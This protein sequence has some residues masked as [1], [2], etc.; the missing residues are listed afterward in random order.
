MDNRR[1]EKL[2]R[3]FSSGEPKKPYISHKNENRA[4]P[5]YILFNKQEDFLKLCTK[6]YVLYHNMLLINTDHIIF[7]AVTSLFGTGS[8][9]PM[10]GKN[11]RHLGN[12]GRLHTFQ[13]KNKTDISFRF[14]AIIN[15]QCSLSLR[16]LLWE[17]GLRLQFAIFQYKIGKV[18]LQVS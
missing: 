7:R 4:I 10:I 13:M 9:G 5:D 17:T 16:I 8:R 14:T 11:Y 15:I 6:I 1:S 3:D 18:C 12:W 2:T